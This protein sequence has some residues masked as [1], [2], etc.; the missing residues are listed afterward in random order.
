MRRAGLR[1]G[2]NK[3]FVTAP[4]RGLRKSMMVFALRRET[5]LRKEE[6]GGRG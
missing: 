5:K 3:K 2:R 4:H 6:K 1:S